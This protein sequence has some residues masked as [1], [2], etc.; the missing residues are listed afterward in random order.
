MKRILAVMFLIFH[1]SC[2]S[3]KMIH[4]VPNLKQVDTGIWRGGQPT[5]EGWTYLKDLGVNKSVKLDLNQYPDTPAESNG[6]QVIYCPIDFLDQ[7]IWKPQK[8]IVELAVHSISNGTFIHCLH[9]QDRT[10]LVVG[11]YRV[12]VQKW[13][14]D[15]TSILMRGLEK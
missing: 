7:T 4:G 13:T 15:A 5:A 14:K 1:T 2:A 10:G 8:E 12:E 3:D 6:I 11:T 9:G